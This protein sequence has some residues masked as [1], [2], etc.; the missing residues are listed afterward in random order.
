MHATEI[1]TLQEALTQAK[2]QMKDAE[3][4]VSAHHLDQ[5]AVTNWSLAG[6]CLEMDNLLSKSCNGS[7]LPPAVLDV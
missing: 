7:L 4:T 6:P 5:C 1:Q 2:E 3:E